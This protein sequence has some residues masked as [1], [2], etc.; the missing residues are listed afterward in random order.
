[1]RMMLPLCGLWSSPSKSKANHEK[2]LRQ[3]PIEEHSIEELTIAPQNYKI[4]K[5]KEILTTYQSQ[6]IRRYNKIS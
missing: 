6:E 2:N 3:I 4:I 5:I 1:M